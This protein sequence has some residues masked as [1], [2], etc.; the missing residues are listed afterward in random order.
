MSS[1]NTQTVPTNKPSL[2]LLKQLLPFMAPYRTAFIGAGVALMVAGVTVLSIV[3]GL[4]Y[5]IDRGFIADNPAMDEQQSCAASLDKMLG[6]DFY[7][8]LLID[9]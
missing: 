7:R 2:K 1:P 9:H 5:V 4:R 6:P 8:C 3:G